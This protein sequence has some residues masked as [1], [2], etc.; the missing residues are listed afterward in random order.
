MESCFFRAAGNIIRP[1]TSALHSY[2]PIKCCIGVLNITQSSD[3]GAS[4]RAV[5]I[6]SSQT[7]AVVMEIDSVITT[8]NVINLNNTGVLAGDGRIVNVTS[9]SATTGTLFYT[10]ADGLTSGKVVDIQSTSV[11]GFTGDLMNISQSGNNTNVTGNV[12][13]LELT[14]AANLGK[15]LNA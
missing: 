4:S 3:S 6:T 13:N 5:Q 7:D 9:D 10:S 15:V 14:G 12:A 2:V 1:L 11:A 8:G